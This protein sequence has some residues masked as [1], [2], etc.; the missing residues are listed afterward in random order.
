M[1]PYGLFNPGIPSTTISWGYPLETRK[2]LF[3]LSLLWRMSIA[4]HRFWKEVD[5]GRHENKVREMVLRE[6]PGEPHD[7]GV[8]CIAPLFDGHLL[9]DF[10]LQPDF[11]RSHQGRFYRVVLGGFLFMFYVSSV[12]LEKGR[13]QSFIQ[14]TGSWIIRVMDAWDIEFL[15]EEARRVAAGTS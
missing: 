14:R 3:Y 2:D 13:D 15:R 12:R 9:T 5:L 8:C 6:D 7:Y 4:S 10:I 11:K 1:R